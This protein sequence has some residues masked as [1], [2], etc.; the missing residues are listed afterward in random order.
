M[1]TILKHFKVGFESYNKNFR[2]LILATLI[3][4]TTLV[5]FILL[6]FLAGTGDVEQSLKGSYYLLF[7]G[8]TGDTGLISEVFEF[9]GPS[10]LGILFIFFLLGSIITILLQTGLW[11]VCLKSIAKKADINVFFNTIKERGGSYIAANLMIWLI[12]IA[13]LIPVLILATII[14]VAFPFLALPE[15]TPLLIITYLIPIWLITPFFIL[16][17]PG[18]ILGKRIS[19]SIE[20]GF[21]LGKENY[22]E[23]LLLIL[24]IYLFSS[25]SLIP[26]VGTFA[27]YLLTPLWMLIICSYYLEKTGKFR[28]EELIAKPVN[29]L[30]KRIV[31]PIIKPKTVVKKII[32]KKP[33]KRKVATK[34]KRVVKKTA[35]KKPVKKKPI[36]KKLKG[37]RK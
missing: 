24:I 32:T 3:I 33:V 23:L 11:G 16:I 2:T 35:V 6:G 25:I 8:N 7:S 18:V 13:I 9:M 12:L 29:L 26:F 27:M 21:S 37:K 14:I 34:P 20:Q 36:V 22:L 15:Y 30:E 31:S 4:F 17:L 19:K 10:N 28:E 5:S 1:C